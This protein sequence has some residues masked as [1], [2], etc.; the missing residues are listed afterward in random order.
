MFS[1]DTLKLISFKASDYGKLTTP[2][3]LSCIWFTKP[4]SREV[5]GCSGWIN[6]NISARPNG[7]RAIVSVKYPG[8]QAIPTTPSE[9]HCKEREKII[10][11]EKCRVFRFL[12]HF[13]KP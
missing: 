1:C 3:D 9:R 11:Q 4:I 2:S 7:Y 5:K 10:L 8:T 12:G 13:V 6:M